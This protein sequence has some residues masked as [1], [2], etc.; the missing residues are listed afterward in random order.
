MTTATPT[1]QYDL[2]LSHLTEHGSLTSREALDYYR[3][4]RL[5]ARIQ[6]LRQDGFDIKSVTKH[7][8]LGKRYVEYVL[9][10]VGVI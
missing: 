5:A 6:E 7:D 9:V 4:F 10:D 2:V 1:T 8:D 3:I